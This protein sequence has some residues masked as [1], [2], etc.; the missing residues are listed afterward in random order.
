MSLVWQLDLPRN[1]RD[2]L[3]VL[4]DHADD[5]GRGARPSVR[6]I[7][8]K[9]GISDRQVIR[10]LVWL[11]DPQRAFIEITRRSGF[12]M[13]NTYRLFLERIPRKSE[14]VPKGDNVSPHETPMGDETPEKGDK[15]DEK[16]DKNPERGDI[17]VSPE[18]LIEPLLAEPLI[19][20]LVEASRKTEEP[21]SHEREEAKQRLRSS[22]SVGDS[23]TFDQWFS[24]VWN[25]VPD[26]GVHSIAVNYFGAMKKTAPLDR[27]KYDQFVRATR[28]RLALKAENA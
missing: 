6:Y 8:W 9:L 2:V 25:A 15:T 27:T 13:P 18:P 28:Q 14:F 11:R 17:A 20:P 19:E 3:L 22:L 23:D 26:A 10:S 5:A 7:A 16:G 12:H 1:E 21:E 24:A 4:A